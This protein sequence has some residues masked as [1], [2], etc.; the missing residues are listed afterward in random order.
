MA[1]FKV[2]GMSEMTALFEELEHLP[3]RVID[4]M[5]MAEADVVKREQRK[6][7]RLM[8]NGPY[9]TGKTAEAIEIGK[10]KATSSGRVITVYPRGSRKRGKKTVNTNAE[11]AFINEYGARGKPARA[12]IRKANEAAAD[13]A[14]DAAEK[15]YDDFLNSL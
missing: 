1:N 11:I 6:A 5:L 8:L 14:F 7:A 12:F 15:V 10:V 13:E 3:D 9:S 4:E 2:E